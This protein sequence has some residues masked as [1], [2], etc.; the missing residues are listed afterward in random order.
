MRRDDPGFVRYLVHQGAGLATIRLSAPGLDVDA[1]EGVTLI[2]N[3]KVNQ[4]PLLEPGL[5]QFFAERCYLAQSVLGRLLDIYSR[6][7]A[8]S[9]SPLTRFVKDLLRLDEL[10]ALV[11]GLHDAGHLARAKNLVPTL[12]RADDLR[13]DFRAQRDDAA[14][15]YEDLASDLM[16]RRNEL[17]LLVENLSLQP[18]VQEAEY[19][20]LEALRRRLTQNGDEVLFVRLIQRRRELES[21]SAGWAE[22]PID[23]DAA[24]RRL[25]EAEAQSAMSDAKVWKETIGAQLEATIE[26][27]RETFPEL[28]SWMTTDP[29]AAHTQA[30]EKVGAEV[31][32]LEKAL[33]Q[34]H[35]AETN[36]NS[37]SAAVARATSR[38][39]VIDEQIAGIGESAGGLARAL[40]EVVPHIHAEDCPVCG[41]DFSETGHGSLLAHV[42]HKIANLTEQA[43]RLSALTTERTQ[44]QARLS[45]LTRQSASATAARLDSGAVLELQARL[46]RLVGPARELTTLFDAAAQGTEL[47]RRQSRA[48]GRL[49]ELRAR[50]HRE[51]DLRGGL[52]A[53]AAQLDQSAPTPAEPFEEVIGRLRVIL[54]ADEANLTAA[55]QARTLA[56]TACDA[57]SAT[58]AKARETSVAR[59]TAAANYTTVDNAFREAERLRGQ[60]RRVGDTA[61]D[62]RTSIVRR[63]F[64]EGLNT[65]WRDLFIRLAPTEP[66][67]PAFRLPETADGV[68]AQLETRTRTGQRAGTPGAMLSAGN[69]NTAA[70]TLFLALHLSVESKF[71]WLVLD[72]PVQ[73]LDE[74]HISQFAALLRTLS[75]D[76]GRKVIIAVH[77]RP[78]F[79]YLRLELSP[80]FDT[81][82][83]ITVEL[84]RSATEETIADSN[85]LPYEGEDV[86][87]A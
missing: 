51:E 57:L 21:L 79:E 72:D 46:A 22:L 84:R 38:L 4:R 42:Q 48:E 37:L 3:G 68:V 40:A 43:G 65:L 2:E 17:H 28:P 77:D 11:E 45:E 47:I 18:P 54:Q 59:D 1:G 16:R 81:D 6:A 73:S 12:R 61:R 82:R 44:T 25:L 69:L 76:H 60:A 50:G 64:N 35:T 14:E 74:V 80:A 33:L 32:R 85:F 5:A 78:L 66:F 56:L 27:V 29:R 41:R 13:Q 39:K 70:L 49:A 26:G 36:A 75:K 23:A 8:Q 24:E 71:P 19:S 10:D 58:E 30:Q 15:A 20:N 52:T 67:V 7:D 9:D 86:V 53:L 63:V 31:L 34:E 62:V 55:R 83:L 87:A